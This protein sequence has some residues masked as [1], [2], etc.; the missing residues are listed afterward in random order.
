LRI[1]PPD[2]D[3]LKPLVSIITVTK[4]SEKFIEKTIKST[5][6]QS[7]TNIEY[8]II[9]GLSNDGT[10]DIIKKYKAEIDYWVSESDRSMYDAINKGIR[11][12]KG[13]IIAIL[14]SDD[15]YVDSD[16]I[17]R[18]VKS[19][20]TSGADGLYGDIII[21]YGKMCRY[22]KVFQVTYKDYILSGK[23]TFVPHS[24]LFIKRR[25]I[26]EVGL[27]NLKYKY[28]SDFDFTLKCLDIGELYYCGYPITLFRRH[29]NSITA[30]GKI[31][32][33]SV[34]ILKNNRLN[35]ISFIHKK[36]YK[37]FLWGKYY[38]NNILFRLL[39]KKKIDLYIK[40]TQNQV[41]N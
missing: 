31:R 19:L 24:S 21:D 38:L 23:G 14:N 10:N 39:Y 9:D 11:K 5:L 30:T 34:D 13:D 29:Q 22:K 7:Y 32:P 4:N 2:I 18:V 36:L 25:L 3:L 27:Y 16:V 33:E 20:I 6:S 41:S 26:D 1:T 37:Y 28:A 12:S 35:N 15:Y 17:S 40:S 8:L